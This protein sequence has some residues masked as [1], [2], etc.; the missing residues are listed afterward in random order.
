MYKQ[1][2]FLLAICLLMSGC[3]LFRPKNKCADCPSWKKQKGHVTENN[4][5]GQMTE[6]NVK[7]KRA[8]HTY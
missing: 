2:F 5:R 7:C 1:F 3:Y 6:N 8:A 4:V